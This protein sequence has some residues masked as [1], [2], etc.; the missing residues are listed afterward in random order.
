[1]DE[2]LRNH[3]ITGFLDAWE[4]CSRTLHLKWQ[5]KRMNRN[6]CLMGMAFAL[7]KDAFVSPVELPS[8]YQ[9]RPAPLFDKVALLRFWTAQPVT[10]LDLCLGVFT[11][12]SLLKERLKQIRLKHQDNPRLDEAAK[13]MRA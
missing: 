9:T 13:K 2:A 3:E 6:S 7:S 1:M 10:L 5:R 12:E 8:T 11:K 4:W